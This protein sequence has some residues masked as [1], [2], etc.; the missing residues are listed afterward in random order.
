MP[1]YKS[2]EVNFSL[3]RTGEALGLL[4][5]LAVTRDPGNPKMLLRTISPFGSTSLIL[6]EVKKR[7][8]DFA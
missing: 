5:T 8:E 7:S 6:K 4:V 2:C 3:G 1:P